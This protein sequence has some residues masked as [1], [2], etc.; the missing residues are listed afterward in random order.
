MS[1]ASLGLDPALVRTLNGLGYDRPTEIQQRAIPVVLS[2]RDVL[3]GA[4]TGTGKT[5]A[6]AL[7]LLQRLSG[8]RA[9][10]RRPR[11]L[12][13]TPTR[14]LALQVRQSFEDYGADRPVRT[15]TLFGGVGMQP[16]IDALRRG[17]EVVVATPGR[18]IDHLQQGHLDLSRLEVLVL[19]EADRML[20]M[21][22]L[23]AIRRILAALP[24]Q[25]QTLLFSATFAAAIKQLAQQFM[26]D[27]VEVQAAPLNSAA[28][29]IEHRIHPVDLAR[30][31]DLLLHL[32]AADSGRQRLV[33]TRTKHG[34]DKLCRLLERAGHR[35]AA[36][37]GN[38]SQG[39]RVRALEG[40]RTGAVQ[41][42][43]ATDIAARGIDIDA[44]P[45]VINY[46]LPM[47]AEDYVHRIGRT[48]RNGQP[49]EAISLVCGEESERLRAIHRLLG[50]EIPQVEV[51]GFV[52]TEPLKLT[53]SGAQRRAAADAP[54]RPPR[55]GG[56]RRGT[57]RRGTNRRPER[58][59]TARR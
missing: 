23:P 8:S 9:A 3:A 4:Q 38:K 45:T 58:A 2:G 24:A 16:Q 44:L 37:H 59:D 39:A 34:A 10:P 52:P 20:D 33:F 12:V 15:C 11:V 43:V 50:R 53:A 56:R 36:I 26:R 29:R 57:A 17:V 51:E 13:L 41:L 27:P 46:E 14:E 19:D 54:A 48:G 49:G 28:P 55:P 32:L 1:F 35:A 22:F 30:K 6:F 18:L 42:L 40:F 31:K 25:R 7:P 5:A 21:G 47:V